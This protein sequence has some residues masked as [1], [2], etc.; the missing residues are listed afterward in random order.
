MRMW[1]VDP[2]IMC[3]EH[4]LGEH[5]EL[6]A[7]AGILTAGKDLTGYYEHQL[8]ELPKLNTRHE[9]LV[10]EMKARGYNHN[11]PLAFDVLV[12][13]KQHPQPPHKVPRAWSVEQLLERCPKC[14]D[15]A[16]EHGAD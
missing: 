12:W 4:L 9:Q 1:M 10:K 11:S 14:R 3:R 7:I 5:R 15:R 2:A 16:D 8:L 6:H 13:L